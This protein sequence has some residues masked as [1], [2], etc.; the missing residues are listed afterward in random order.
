MTRCFLLLASVLFCCN[1]F[2][3]ELRGRVLAADSSGPIAGASIFLSNT[4]IGTVA[5]SNGEFSIARLPEGR[6]DLVVSSV[7]FET[8]VISLQTSGI[9]PGFIVYLKP[10][11]K[12][13]EAVIVRSYEKDGWKR[14]GVFFI[15]TLIGT[16][17]AA[18]KCNLKNT[19]AI[20]FVHNRKLK[21]LRAYASEALVIENRELGYLLTYQLE[22]FEYDF[23]KG[24]LIY[25]GYPLF[26]D[27]KPRSE[28]QVKRWLQNRNESYD[29]SMMH[30]MRAL[31]RN[32]VMQAGFEMRKLK[33]IP[34]PE[35]QRIKPL[36][37]DLLIK[38][39]S[40]GNFPEQSDRDSMAY[41]SAVMANPGTKDFLINELLP[42]DSVEYAEDSVSAGFFFEDYLHITYTKKKESTEFPGLNHSRKPD[43]ITSRIHLPAKRP[44]TVLANGSYYNGKD[45][46]TSGYWA[47][48]EKLADMLPLD[49]WPVIEK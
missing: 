19:A 29:G 25:E 46:L 33:K 48:S 23:N 7:G 44:L 39:D 1:V 15:E 16:S 36:Y 37:D 20:K 11:A 2:S 26:K 47:W 22:D 21:L 14:W 5:I 8:Q 43:W 27:M 42:G 12:E 6:F 38:K 9:Q 24:Q 3:Q 10:K 35:A 4:S 40:T 28:R 45:L 49:F 30:F 17:A 31:F 13:L 41:Y 32:R 18:K 34:G